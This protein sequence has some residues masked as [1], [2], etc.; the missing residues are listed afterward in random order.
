MH[1]TELH[2][3]LSAGNLHFTNI[4]AVDYQQGRTYACFVQN[5]VMRSIQQGEYAR[6]IPQGGKSDTVKPRI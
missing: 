2:L 6:V 4:E 1:D 3:L 5:K